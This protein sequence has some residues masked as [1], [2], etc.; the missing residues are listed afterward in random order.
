MYAV[1]KAIAFVKED[2]KNRCN[3]N[4]RMKNWSLAHSK[5]NDMLYILGD[6]L[7][8]LL[9][10]NLILNIHCTYMIYMILIFDL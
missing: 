5:E 1:R 6:L 9:I 7:E 10:I 4:I 2:P 8:V 3:K